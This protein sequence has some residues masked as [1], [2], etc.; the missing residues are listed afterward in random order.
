MNIGITRSVRVGL[1]V[2]TRIYEKGREMNRVEP[3]DRCGVVLGFRSDA[4]QL[5]GFG[6]M[7]CHNCYWCVAA[8]DDKWFG[9]LDNGCCYWQFKLP[10]CSK[11]DMSMGDA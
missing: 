8:K 7:Y 2:R 3:C 6:A 10:G 5:I 1:V 9:V 4:K 11:Q